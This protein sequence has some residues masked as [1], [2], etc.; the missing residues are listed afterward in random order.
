MKTS[1]LERGRIYLFRVMEV[2][3]RVG[4]EIFFRHL[5]ILKYVIVPFRDELSCQLIFAVAGIG[6]AAGSEEEDMSS[7]QGM[8]PCSRSSGER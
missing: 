3:N 2:L 5:V 8:R 6:T 7:S 4:D 1:D